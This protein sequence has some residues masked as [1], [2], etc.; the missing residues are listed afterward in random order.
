MV[1]KLPDEMN[2]HDLLIRLD[3]K[4]DSLMKLFTN[5][6]SHHQRFTISLLTLLGGALMS[7]I[8]AYFTKR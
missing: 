4:Q 3:E 7:L 6:L 8:V 1:K 5:H 2:D